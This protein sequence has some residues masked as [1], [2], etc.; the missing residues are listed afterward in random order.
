MDVSQFRLYIKTRIN[1]NARLLRKMIKAY[2]VFIKDIF[3]TSYHFTLFPG[4]KNYILILIV[5][6]HLTYF[7]LSM[8]LLD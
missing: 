6:E 2:K 5:A 1:R 8:C 3:A 7:V 4:E